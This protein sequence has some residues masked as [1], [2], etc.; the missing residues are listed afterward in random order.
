MRLMSGVEVALANYPWKHDRASQVPGRIRRSSRAQ[1]AKLGLHP[2]PFGDLCVP[3]VSRENPI[4]RSWLE[5]T[6]TAIKRATDFATFFA[7][8]AR[9][10]GPGGLRK[11]L[12]GI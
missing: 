6:L 8:L 3:E 10:M 2:L 4:F 5:M 11:S 1:Q 7:N 9:V 12:V